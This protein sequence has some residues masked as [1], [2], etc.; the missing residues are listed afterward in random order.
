M[1]QDARAILLRIQEATVSASTNLGE[2]LRLCKV[3]ASQFDSAPLG[4]WIRLETEGYPDDI[5]LPTYRVWPLIIK[6]HFAGPFGVQIK[7]ATI[8]PGNIPASI[9]DGITEYHCRQGLSVVEKTA[10]PYDGAS[11]LKVPLGKYAPT[12]GENVFEDMVCV[13]VWGIFS[14]SNLQVVLDAVR[15]K[16]LDFALQLDKEL[17]VNA[18]VEK[19]GEVSHAVSQVFNTV[20]YGNMSGVV[21]A[22]T[23]SEIHA[24]T[25]TS[26]DL[27]GMLD[28]LAAKGVPKED[29][30]ELVA[31][32]KEDPKPSHTDKYGPQVTGWVGKMMKKAAQGTWDIGVAAAGGLL[33]EVLMRFYGLK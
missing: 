9:R 14:A 27:Q 23:N 22:A 21:G 11:S 6:G 5:E 2:A 33:S 15:N 4:D 3:L 28:S 13:D 32:V 12:I 10:A 30:E 8:P 7:N 16:I 29:L 20:V 19:P 1:K 17:P 18:I 26:G 25:I 31:A 24:T